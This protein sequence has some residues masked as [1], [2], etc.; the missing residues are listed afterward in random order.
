MGWTH[1]RHSASASP[2]AAEDEAEEAAE[3]R[4]DTE[5]APTA[6][7]ADAGAAAGLGT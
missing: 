2:G 6:S 4:A 5:D 1:V 7:E 3:G